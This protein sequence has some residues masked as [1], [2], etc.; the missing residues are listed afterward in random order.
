M[1]ASA[2]VAALAGIAVSA[3]VAVRAEQECRCADLPALEN[4]LFQQEYLQLRFREYDVHDPLGAY[5]AGIDDI[6]RNVRAKFDCY[7]ELGTTDTNDPAFTACFRT[8]RQGQADQ[9]ATGGGKKSEVPAETD[10]S[11]SACKIRLNMPDGTKLDLTA[12]NEKKWR[13]RAKSPC[14]AVNDFLLAH[15]RSHQQVCKQSWGG[16][17]QTDYQKG[18]F[19]AADDARA[20]GAGIR[21]LRKSIAA[22]A[23]QC[24]WEG[25]TAATRKS[26]DKEKQDV[27]VVPTPERARELATALKVVAKG[28]K[29]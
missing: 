18:D 2:Y 6:Q 13:D 20:Y 24:G 1:R 11:S 23:H 28:G 12:G 10:P 22:L 14:K 8:T 9:P 27:D 25:S 29:R 7:M 16:N 3:P 17:T 15:E 21:Q 5:S 19:F 26:K 4:D